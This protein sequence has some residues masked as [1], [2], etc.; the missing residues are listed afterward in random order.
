[1]NKAMDSFVDFSGRRIVLSGATSGIGSAIA[2][3]L[4]HYNAN[5]V[6]LGR[7]QEKLDALKNQIST[8]DHHSLVIDLENTASIAN[9]LKPLFADLKPLYGLCHCAGLVETR[10]LSASRP[11][12]LDRHMKVNLVAG[13]ELSRLVANRT[14]CQDGEG[15]IVFMSSV[16]ASVGAPGQIAYCASKG[17]ANSAVKAMAL[18]M[19]PRKIRV[20]SISSGFIRTEMTARN[21]RLNDAQTSSIIDKHPLGEGNAIDVARAT[22]FLLAPENRWITGIDLKVDGG[23]TAQ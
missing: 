13:I 12:V 14:L 9:S 10:P 21:S 17:A 4:A 1:M 16:Y 7:N 2:S 19:A 18:E 22:A 3:L 15:S 20:N 8:G 5:L 6:L 11:E 23:Y